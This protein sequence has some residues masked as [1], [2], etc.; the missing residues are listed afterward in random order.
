[1]TLK[2]QMKGKPRSKSCEFTAGRQSRDQ[3]IT[4]ILDFVKVRTST[5]FAA[6]NQGN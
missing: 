6:Q 1:M 2:I 4:A 5:R 3:L